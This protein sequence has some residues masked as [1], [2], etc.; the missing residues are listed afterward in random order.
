MGELERRAGQAIEERRQA[1]AEEIV[2]RLY[3][4]QGEVWEPFGRAG[5][6]KSVRDAGYHLAYL[7]EALAAAQPALFVDYV[8]WVQA[9]FA[10]LGLAESALPTTLDCTQAVLREDLSDELAEAALPYLEAGR[11]ALQGHAATPPIHIEEGAPLSELA[12]AYIEALLRGD[13][14][15]ASRMILEAVEAGAPIRD[16]YLDVFQHAQHE[17]GR[18]WQT[19]Q[20]SVAQEHL[21]T[22]MTQMIMSQLYPRIFS[23]ERK[24][25]VMVATCVGGELHEIGVRMVADFFEMEGWDTFYLGANTPARSVIQT[26]VERQAD[27]LAISAT[28]TYHVSAVTE[29]ISQVR[30][31]PETGDVAIMVG[32]YPFN[33]APELWRSVGADGYARNAAEAVEVGEGLVRGA[34]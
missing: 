30:Q 15:A 9:L 29:L 10:G 16:I 12:G 4:L 19:N 26:I 11:A 5:R 6:E 22:A 32:G 23:T 33:V 18:L 28:I 2:A 21:A 20:I 7:A 8:R 17:I 1:L 25:R 13:R 14:R 31:A 34:R 24:G 27:L 3:G